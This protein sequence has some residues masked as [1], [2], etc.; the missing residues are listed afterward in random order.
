MNMGILYKRL[1]VPGRAVQSFGKALDIKR[2]LIGAQSLPV[3]NVLE[4]LGKY[5]L[6]RA[7]YG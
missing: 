2:Q 6:E 5:H 4:E 3:A 7:D 1:G